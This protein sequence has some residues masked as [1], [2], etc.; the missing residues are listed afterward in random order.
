M[1]RPT[2]SLSIKAIEGELLPEPETYQ[3]KLRAAVF[4]GVS[5][6]DV[7]DVVKSITA[8]AKAGDPQAT[9]LFFDFVLGSKKQ[10]TV[11]NF[12]G[13]VENAARIAKTARSQAS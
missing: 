2:R 4:D 13:S 12:L 7:A 1:T 11:N 9:K 5:E 3:A 8:K 10:V 6:A